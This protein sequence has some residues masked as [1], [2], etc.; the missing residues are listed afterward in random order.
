MAGIAHWPKVYQRS[1]LPT[2]VDHWRVPTL[3]H[4]SWA[5]IQERFKDKAVVRLEL[6]SPQVLKLLLSMGVD[7]IDGDNGVMLEFADQ[8]SAYSLIH[9]CTT[10]RIKA[11]M[12]LDGMMISA[13]GGVE[14]SLRVVSRYPEWLKKNHTPGAARANRTHLKT[15]ELETNWIKNSLR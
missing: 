1:D 4:C 6:T 12:Y 13:W 11:A 8:D 2:V 5:L 3:G 9:Y 7:A 14:H 10:R 15:Y